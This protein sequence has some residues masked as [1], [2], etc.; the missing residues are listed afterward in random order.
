MRVD[1][2]R[3]YDVHPA[4]S[5]GEHHT[6]V[7]TCPAARERSD[8]SPEGLGGMRRRKPLESNLLCLYVRHAIPS[9]PFLRIRG[10]VIIYHTRPNSI[11]FLR[12][13]PYLHPSVPRKRNARGTHQSQQDPH[14][15][16]TNPQI[17]NILA[18]AGYKLNISKTR[19]KNPARGDRIR[20]VYLIRRPK[21]DRIVQLKGRSLPSHLR[22]RPHPQRHAVGTALDPQRLGQVL[23]VLQDT[24]PM[25]R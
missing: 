3:T 18:T 12:P 24:L 22:H 20:A 7:P 17:L 6:M 16:L 21:G 8:S 15:P 19:N 5:L 11:H 1:G 4:G 23:A 13:K 14:S 25:Q 9:R 2:A 10:R